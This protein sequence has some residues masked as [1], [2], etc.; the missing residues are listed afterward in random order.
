[1]FGSL[2]KERKAIFCEP[3]PHICWAELIILLQT[4]F[5]SSCHIPKAAPFRN[6]AVSYAL[7]Q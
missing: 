7:M 6:D 2:L 1:M 3:N 5:A 4:P